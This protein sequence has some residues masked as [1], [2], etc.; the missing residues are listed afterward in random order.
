M[1]PPMEL[2]GDLKLNPL[3]ALEEVLVEKLKLVVL[4]AVV[5]LPS[6]NTGA[7]PG[8]DVLVLSESLNPPDEVT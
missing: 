7:S 4:E 8:L 3:V 2:G 5:V 6:L 1:V